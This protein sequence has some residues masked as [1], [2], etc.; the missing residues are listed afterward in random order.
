[1]TVKIT[2]N[3]R[4]K[5]YIAVLGN[6]VTVV[7]GFDEKLS[8]RDSDASIIVKAMAAGQGFIIE[9]TTLSING[10]T[11]NAVSIHDAVSDD[12]EAVWSTKMAYHSGCMIHFYEADIDGRIRIDPSDRTEKLSFGDI[13]VPEDHD[14]CICE[15][16]KRDDIPFENARQRALR[17][18]LLGESFHVE[19]IE[20]IS[21]KSPPAPTIQQSAPATY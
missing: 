3:A 8:L 17:K 9:D 6:T 4:I 15:I 16:E 20:P 14:L 21:P 19:M 18:L 12:D 2:N 1:M 5:D 11:Y 10:T 13:F 7:G